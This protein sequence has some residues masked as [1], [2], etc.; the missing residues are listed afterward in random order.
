MVKQTD[1][2]QKA[3]NAIAIKVEERA[4][5][6]ALGR[7][8]EGLLGDFVGGCTIMDVDSPPLERRYAD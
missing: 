5:I 8:T 7:E 6:L 3:Q 4:G 1:G 2:I